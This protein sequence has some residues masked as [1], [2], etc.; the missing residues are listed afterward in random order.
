MLHVVQWFNYTP[1]PM[2]IWKETV[3]CVHGSHNPWNGARENSFI[4]HRVCLSSPS[5]VNKF[6]SYTFDNLTT[7]AS[8]SFVALRTED[9]GRGALTQSMLPYV[10][11]STCCWKHRTRGK[12]FW[13]WILFPILA[14]RLHFKQIRNA[15]LLYSIFNLTKCFLIL[16]KK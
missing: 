8:K 16:V 13:K 15:L 14:M 5:D 12:C 2:S 7:T 11:K 1:F 3:V 6:A 9:F 4:F 10:G